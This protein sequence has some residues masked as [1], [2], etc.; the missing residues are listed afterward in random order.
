MLTLELGVKEE[1]VSPVRQ[2]E[3]IFIDL[4]IDDDE[5]KGEQ[6][7]SEEEESPLEESS[8][9]EESISDEDDDGNNNCHCDR[10]ME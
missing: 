8:S 10:L 4:T 1:C 2:K 9:N 7:E 5:G 3:P 6:L